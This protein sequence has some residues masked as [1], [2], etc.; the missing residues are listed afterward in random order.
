MG[1]TFFTANFVLDASKLQAV[2]VSVR[3]VKEAVM[4]ALKNWRPASA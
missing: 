2:G 1:T 4:D 3:P